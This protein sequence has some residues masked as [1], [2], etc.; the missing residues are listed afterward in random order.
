[1]SPST[2]RAIAA[3]RR[4][5]VGLANELMN[6]IVSAW[7]PR[8]SS[9]ASAPRTAA[10]SSG[11]TSFPRAPMRPGTSMVCSSAASGS[12]FGQMIHPA[13]PPGT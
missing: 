8:R 3:A 10:S 1:M 5:W 6:E 2:S 7:M 13:K 11:A 9:S 12:G 4:S